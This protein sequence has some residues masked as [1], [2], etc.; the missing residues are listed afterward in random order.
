MNVRVHVFFWTYVFISLLQNP[1]S[2]TAGS[3][4]KFKIPLVLSKI[5]KTQ[6]L[7]LWILEIFKT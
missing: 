2:G 6:Q 4:G 1:V 3:H 7:K 5:C